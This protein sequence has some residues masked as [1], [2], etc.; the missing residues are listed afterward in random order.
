[1]E[2][3]KRQY[4]GIRYP[5]MND[6]YQKFYVD[7]NE[8]VKG[9][10][11]SQVM[12]VLF[13]PKGQKIRDPEFGTDLIKFIFDQNDELTWASVKEEINASLSRWVTNVSLNDIQIA[14]DAEEGSNIFVRVDYS[15]KDG[16]SVTNDSIGVKL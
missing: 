1:M 14:R 5:F 10:V 15:V 2:T 6:G 8:D 9:K 12:H 3:I 4:F 13:T 11:R 7:A 16:N